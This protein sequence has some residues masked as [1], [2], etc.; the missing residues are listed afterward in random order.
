MTELQRKIFKFIKMT[1]KKRNEK[2]LKWEKKMCC[3]FD[4]M[5]G[6]HIFQASLFFILAC[7]LQTLAK[8]ILCNCEMFCPEKY[9]QAH[10]QPAS[11]V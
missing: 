8:Q 2:M 3:I 7:T 6:V 11:I 5:M 1:Y 4:P 9:S 10:M